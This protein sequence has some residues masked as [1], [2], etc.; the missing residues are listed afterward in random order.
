MA[1]YSEEILDIINKSY[2]HYTAEQIYSV[3][4][5]RGDKIVLATVYNNLN[6]LT[7]NGAI[8]RIT[9]EGSPDHYDKIR[10]HDHLVCS[11]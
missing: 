4:K 1:R 2:E 8:R 3:M 7:D 10:R 11:K 9:V 6:K 5:N